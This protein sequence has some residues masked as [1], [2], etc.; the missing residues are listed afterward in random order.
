MGT[1]FFNEAVREKARP[2]FCAAG[3][4]TLFSIRDLP[5]EALIKQIPTEG[6]NRGFLCFNRITLPPPSGFASQ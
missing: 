1:G 4:L 6:Q 2:G 3:F 5:S